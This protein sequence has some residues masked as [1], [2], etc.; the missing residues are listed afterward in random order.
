MLERETAL[1]QSVRGS[2]FDVKREEN[3][4]KKLDTATTR[5][6]E[7]ETEL[8]EVVSRLEMSPTKHTHCMS[9]SQNNSRKTCRRLMAGR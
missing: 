5:I 6:T 1:L 7:L 8:R 3:L 9:F 4:R 2:E